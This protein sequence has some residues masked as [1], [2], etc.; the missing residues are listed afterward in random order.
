MS[1][2]ALAADIGERIALPDFVT[3]KAIEMLVGRTSRNLAECVNDVTSRFAA[4]MVDYPIALHTDKANAQHYEVPA[5]FFDLVLGP[6]RKYSCCLYDAGATT[7]EEAEEAA[8][9]ATAAYAGL[10]DG[11]TILELGCGWGSLSLWMARHFPNAR[12]LAVSNSH[13][14]GVSIR[15]RAKASGFSNLEVLTAN[16][17]DFVPPQRFDRIVS[18]EMFEHMSN[19]RPLLARAREALGTEGRFY[20]HIFSHRSTPYRFD[21]TDP[22]DWIARHFFTGGIMPSHDLVREFGDLFAVEEEWRWNGR[23][24]ARTASAWLDNLDRHSD[25]VGEILR[26]VYGSD[27]RLWRRRWR[28]FFLATMGLFGHGDGSEWGV[29]HYRLAPA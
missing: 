28:L 3:R 10:A 8:L 27:W 24:Y 16:M 13:S 2:I 4:A 20:I 5:A 25:R 12:I 14:Q 26:D 29:S 17:N 7:L 1:T 11:Q 22:A 15:T 23:N 19:W 21:H 18:V 9:A 6:Q